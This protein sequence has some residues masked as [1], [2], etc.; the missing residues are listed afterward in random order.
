M[1]PCFIRLLKPDGLH[2]VDYAAASLADAARFEPDDGV[3]TVT[4]TYNTYQALKL[5]AHLDRMENSARLAGMRLV[6]NRP[7][8][9]WALRQ[10]IAEAGY[11]DVRFRVT[12]LRDQPDS[13]IL[14]LEPFRPL[15][16]DVLERGVRCASVPHAARHNPAAKTTNWMHAR[17]QISDSLPQGVYEALLLDDGGYI[18]EGLSSNFYAV[19]DGA[20]RT[21]GD[22][23]LPGIAQQVVYDIAPAIIPVIRSPAHIDDVSRLE[24]AF[25]TSS[26]RGIVPVIAIDDHGIGEGRPGRI[27]A[28]LRQSYDAWVAAHLEDL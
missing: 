28:A 21:A 12:A 20:L 4:N 16:L 25:I 26:S 15:S 6:V 10:M 7:Y 5:D 13:Y 8:V 19:L 14:S 1:S 2:P 11:G 17:K 22:G 27:T 9:R 3:Y 18:L 23:V 24:E